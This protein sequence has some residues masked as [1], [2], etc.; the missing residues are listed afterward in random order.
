[1]ARQGAVDGYAAGE[2]ATRAPVIDIS[3]GLLLICL[4]ATFPLAI[5]FSLVV[6]LRVTLM[7]INQR[8]VF[9]LRS[10]LHEQG[11]T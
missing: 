6:S 2:A 3:V 8:S 10:C 11:V 5:D 4:L 9:R 7:P 1:V